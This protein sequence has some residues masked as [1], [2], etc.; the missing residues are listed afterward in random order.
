MTV[1]A[2]IIILMGLGAI[3]DGILD[4]RTDSVSDDF[5][6]TTNATASTAQVQLTNTLW[7][8]ETVYASVSSNTTAD[9]PTMTG[10]TAASKAL[11]IGGLAS[12]TTRILTV[13]YRTFALTNFPG[14]DTG[15]RFFPALLVLA[16]VAI[17]LLAVVFTILGR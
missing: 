7:E 12:N 2:A 10:Y 14:A 11:D 13:T 9:S 6:V 16:V 8:G 17:P 4:F 15:I 3:T 1:V 5:S